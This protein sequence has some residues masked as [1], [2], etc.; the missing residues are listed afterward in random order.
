VT[1]IPI[2]PALRRKLVVWGSVLITVAVL[3]FGGTIAGAYYLAFYA[4]HHSETQAAQEQ[5]QQAKGECTALLVLDNAKHGIVFS[6]PG[7]SEVYIEREIA[8]I[9]GVIV[10][11][12]C[13]QLLKQGDK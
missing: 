7:P 8:G 10:A 11:S 13:A 12:H 3:M 9:H 6:K 4:V 5:I 1:F 2:S